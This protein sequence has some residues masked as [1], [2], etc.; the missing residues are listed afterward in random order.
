MAT[1]HLG[2]L[3]YRQRWLAAGEKSWA[4]HEVAARHR[5]GNCD[6]FRQFVPTPSDDEG[7]YRRRSWLVMNFELRPFC[8]EILQHHTYLNR[9]GVRSGCR[10]CVTVVELRWIASRHPSR[11]AGNRRTFDVPCQ[12]NQ[13]AERRALK[14]NSVA[15]NDHPGGLTHPRRGDEPFELRLIGK[16]GWLD[17]CDV[18]LLCRS[19]VC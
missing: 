18:K 8:Q 12:A 9:R 17:R 7:I 13:A 14:H 15:R 16:E 10:A 2:Y 1:Q 11:N 6:A 19:G 3:L 4:G 5:T